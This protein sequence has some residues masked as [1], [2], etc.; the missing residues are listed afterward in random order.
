MELHQLSS[1]RDMRDFVVLIPP[2]PPLSLT[3]S[4]K[5]CALSFAWTGLL[6]LDQEDIC[7]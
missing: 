3:H 1:G 5:N 2:P 4:Y 7:C 6:L